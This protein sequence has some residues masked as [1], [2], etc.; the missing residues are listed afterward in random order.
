MRGV[1]SFQSPTLIRGSSREGE[2]HD[3]RC[4]DMSPLAKTIFLSSKVLGAHASRWLTGQEPQRNQCLRTYH[5]LDISEVMTLQK[6]LV[7]WVSRLFSPA[8]VDRESGWWIDILSQTTFM[9]N[10]CALL[11]LGACL[12]IALST[13]DSYSSYFTSGFDRML[14]ESYIGEIFKLWNMPFYYVAEIIFKR[15]AFL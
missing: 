5:P 4:R 1:K 11:Y 3:T 15:V 6:G 8:R 9:S 2:S 14:W 13:R 7:L 12:H 10:S